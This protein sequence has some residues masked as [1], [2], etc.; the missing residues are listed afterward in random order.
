MMILRMRPFTLDVERQDHLRR[1][2]HVEEVPGPGAIRR[3]GQAGV[4]QVLR[5]KITSGNW[6][7][8]VFVPYSQYAAEESWSDSA[9]QDGRTV[10][11]SVPID[12]PGAHASMQLRLGQEYEWLP[13]RLTLERFDAV[14]Y[15]GMGSTGSSLMRDFCS[16]LTI[17][18]HHTGEKT[19]D[20]AHMN[21]PVYF[22]GGSWLFFQANGIPRASAGRSWAWATARA[23]TS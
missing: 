9:T 17:E 16:T 19:T 8:E 22:G 2:E 7:R 4:F 3:A 12:I 6:S 20:V 14:P 10:A 13:A 18:D 5:V 15:A 1:N 23:W 11:R 21:H